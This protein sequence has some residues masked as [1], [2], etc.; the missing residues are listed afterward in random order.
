MSNLNENKK[1]TEKLPSEILKSG[2][3]SIINLFENKK[4]EYYKNISDN[5]LIINNLQKKIKKL[6]KENYI[7][8][9]NNSHQ[10]KLIE[11]LKNENNDLKN[12][13]NNI[14]GKLNI[15][16]NMILK[17]S[18]HNNN[19][20]NNKI[21]I[22][23]ININNFGN[24]IKTRNTRHF[25]GRI[26][27]SLNDN[28]CLTDRNY[29]KNNVLNSNIIKEKL[30]QNNL[31]QNFSYNE[32]FKN[33]DN[34]NYYNR[35]RTKNNSFNKNTFKN[36]LNNKNDEKKNK[37]SIIKFN[38]NL[39]NEIENNKKIVYNLSDSKN[40]INKFS[41]KK[42]S[43]NYNTIDINKF[44]KD[45]LKIN[46]FT[47]EFDINKDINYGNHKSDNNNNYLENIISQTKIIYKKKSKK[48]LINDFLKKC[49]SILD[50][51]IYGN[52]LQM[53][54][55]YKDEAIIQNEIIQNIHTQ[56]ENNPELLNELDNIF[57]GSIK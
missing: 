13:I 40:V 12:I 8:K 9:K 38:G 29:R 5:Q 17:N 25:S 52:I 15:D 14:K 11:E 16:S 57:K 50:N 53:F 26:Y 36:I 54:Q 42:I 47:T 46:T 24:S 39:N 45:H 2:I 55:D 27:S 23:K 21:K 49:K 7:L 3:D 10:N 19:I 22:N 43:K 28:V 31:A 20:N 6:I 30:S 56:L 4:N 35:L 44:K 48:N 41:G 51:K 33:N 32:Y 1:E 34:S 37:L 18:I